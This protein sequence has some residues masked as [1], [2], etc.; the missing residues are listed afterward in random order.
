MS[1]MDRNPPKIHR[2]IISDVWDLETASAVDVVGFEVDPEA[3]RSGRE[4][5]RP[6]VCLTCLIGGDGGC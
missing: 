3:A 4:R 2:T 5:D 1:R 6:L